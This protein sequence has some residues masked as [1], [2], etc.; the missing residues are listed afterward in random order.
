M[1]CSTCGTIILEIAE[2]RTDLRKGIR[3]AERYGTTAVIANLAPLKA[4][5]VDRLA[6]QAYH[7]EHQHD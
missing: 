6:K 1:G 2:A 7:L 3:Q 5:I 4:A